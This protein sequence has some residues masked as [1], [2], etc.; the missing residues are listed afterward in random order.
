MV[1]YAQVE[2]KTVLRLVI[3]N[4]QTQATDIDEFFDAVVAIAQRLEQEMSEQLI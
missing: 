1:N 3:C 2:G 4:N